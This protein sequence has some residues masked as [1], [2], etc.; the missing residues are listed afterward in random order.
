MKKLLLIAAIAILGSCNSKKEKQ[1]VTGADTT[2]PPDTSTTNTTNSTAPVGS[3]TLSYMFNDT[4]RTQTASA[5]V[6]KD[7][8][9]L[10]PGNDL[11]AIV[12]GSGSN[13][14][15]L[16]V[17]FIFALK[18]GV[19]PVVGLGYTRPSQVFGG[20]L[21]GEAELTKYKVN[22]TEVTDLGSN[23]AGGHR[24]KLS[25]SIDEEV[26][27]DA[28]SLMK[29]DPKHPAAVKL[30]K[31]SFSNLSF[32]DNWEELLNKAMEKMKSN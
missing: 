23:N 13:D 7:E 28:M 19:Y 32:D 11:L 30:N 21:G 16:T 25:G 31:I 4:A 2:T 26:T 10:S 15:T 22:L 3:G 29:L 27:I 20:I 14:E 17:N 6:S 9:K 5:L 1:T 18:P 12:T 8:D 24:W